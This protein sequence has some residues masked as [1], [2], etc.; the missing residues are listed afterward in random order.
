ME[1]GVPLCN[2]DKRSSQRMS[3]NYDLIIGGGGLAGLS[4]AIMAAQSGYEVLVIEKSEYPKQKVCGEYI[5]NE[6]RDFL[7]RIG[8][9]FEKYLLPEIKKFRLSFEQGNAAECTLK[10]GA[11]GL[12][13]YTLDAELA[14]IARSHGAEILTQERVVDCIYLNPGFEVQTHKNKTF[15]GELFL[16]CFGR[17]SGFESKKATN[18]E[19]IGVKY[20]LHEGPESDVIEIHNFDGGY[21]GV[22]Q[23]EDD[24]YCLCYLVKAEKVKPYKSD[25]EAFEREIMSKNPLLAKRLSAQK[26]TAGVITSRFDFGVFQEDTQAII[27]L[28]DS[29]GFIPPITGNG[30]SLAFRAAQEHYPIIEHFLQGDKSFNDL[31]RFNN[32]YIKSYLK[33]RVQKGV[34][35][36][37]ILFLNNSLLQ[38]ALIRLF[39]F[40]PFI[41]KKLTQQAIGKPF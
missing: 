33:A 39:K 30:M 3:S 11:F 2:R 6:S 9:P 15:R 31:L 36:Q 37:N 23:V 32:T 28:G 38:S 27:R 20:H 1:M 8:F 14:Q 17:N 19:F 10:L 5:S 7:A 34:F 21:C 29:A 13:R 26:L 16:G 35:L 24:K 40:S 22:S 4:L 18:N 12:S 41:M 25:F